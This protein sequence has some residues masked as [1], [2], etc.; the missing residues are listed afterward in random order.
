MIAK[1]A[2]KDGLIFCRAAHTPLFAGNVSLHRQQRE[3]KFRE[4][5]RS[6]K[7]RADD[8]CLQ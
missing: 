1:A 4:D 7:K 6:R 8:W 2:R 5:L 3:G